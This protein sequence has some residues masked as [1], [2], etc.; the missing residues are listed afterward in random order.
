[1]SLFPESFMVLYLS[2]GVLWPWLKISPQ[3]S[4]NVIY[5]IITAW[6]WLMS[7]L[8]TPCIPMQIKPIKAIMARVGAL[9]LRAWPR[10]LGRS[11]LERVTTLSLFLPRTRQSVW[12]LSHLSHN[13][14]D[15]AGWWP[16]H[17]GTV[18]PQLTSWVG[19]I[20]SVNTLDKGII[21]IP[22]GTDQTVQDF[23]MLLRMKQFKTYELYISGIFH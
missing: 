5:L 23:I 1:M 22:G 16:H 8:Y 17:K 15:T 21:H 2:S 6:Q 7:F 3:Y 10:A 20:Y 11:P 19:S 14:T 13:D 4:L 9:L 12:N 18:T